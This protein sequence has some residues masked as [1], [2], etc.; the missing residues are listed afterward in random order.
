MPKPHIYGES[1]HPL[2]VLKSHYETAL[3][4]FT[5]DLDMRVEQ[6][7]ALAQLARQQ[8]ASEEAERLEP[9]RRTEQ[10]Q[11]FRLECERRGAEDDLARRG[12]AV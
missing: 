2:N 7:K 8:G 1:E 4:Q 12:K 11:A 9:D 3:R 5:T 10:T 6:Q